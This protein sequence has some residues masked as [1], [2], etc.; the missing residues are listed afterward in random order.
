LSVLESNGG[1]CQ[2]SHSLFRQLRR[3]IPNQY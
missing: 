1:H 3:A 2:I